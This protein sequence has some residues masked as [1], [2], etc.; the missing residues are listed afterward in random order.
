MSEKTQIYVL[1]YIR[2][3]VQRTAL[4]GETYSD[5]IERVFQDE[6]VTIKIP[7]GLHNI[8]S[9]VAEG[10]KTEARVVNVDS[11]VATSITRVG[12]LAGF[13]GE[14]FWDWGTQEVAK[15]NLITLLGIDDNY[16]ALNVIMSQTMSTLIERF[17]AYEFEPILEQTLEAI[18]TAFTRLFPEEG[19]A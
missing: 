12:A 3:L 17:G 1:K 13:R 14:R 16:N 18:A 7:A 11:L 19:E 10:L 4:P 9:Q 15:A 5:T 8:L 2:D 6:T